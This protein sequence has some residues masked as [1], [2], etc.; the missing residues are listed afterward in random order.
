M[1]F[2]SRDLFVVKIGY[3]HYSHSIEVLLVEEKNRV[4]R[5]YSFVTITALKLQG[6]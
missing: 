4:F 6:N 1:E 3:S 2:E 5:C